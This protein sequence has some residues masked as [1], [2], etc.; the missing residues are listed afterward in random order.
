M[1]ACVIS[2][3]DKI[4]VNSPKG[5]PYLSLISKVLRLEQKRSF[6]H[7]FFDLYCDLRLE[8][9]K[10]HLAIAYVP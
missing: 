4:Q 8:L 2:L 6:V 5:W 9:F 3:S 10:N 7:S 1:N